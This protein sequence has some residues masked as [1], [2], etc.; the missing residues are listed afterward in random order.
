ME[1]YF[2]LINP[3][4]SWK[5]EQE[6]S[7]SLIFLFFEEWLSKLTDSFHLSTFVIRKFATCKI[8]WTLK[9]E[10]LFVPC[11]GFARDW[12]FQKIPLVFNFQFQTHFWAS[13]R[14]YWL[15]FFHQALIQQFL[16]GWKVFRSRMSSFVNFIGSG[17]NL[18]SQKVPLL[19]IFFRS[20]SSNL[21]KITRYNFSIKVS[22]DW[23][24]IVEIH[25][26]QNVS[27]F[28]ELW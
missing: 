4:V 7:S 20:S 11:N 9:L 6:L 16:V 1:N 8:Q 28:L 15:K 5:T 19:I 14:S 18:G 25:W 13:V 26:T 23:G 3:L 21:F 17:L 12:K 22:I 27:V 10:F 2:V 24:E